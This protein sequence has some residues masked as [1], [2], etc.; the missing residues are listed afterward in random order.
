MAS[1]QFKFE[2]PRNISGFNSLTILNS[3]IPYLR[4][5]IQEY[6]GIRVGFA[7]TFEMERNETGETKN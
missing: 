3:S 5:A 7:F 1:K 2:N 4:Q 6:K